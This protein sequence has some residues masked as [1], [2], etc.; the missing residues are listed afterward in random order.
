MAALLKLR[1]IQFRF[2]D[3]LACGFSKSSRNAKIDIYFF[4]GIVAPN[5]APPVSHTHSFCAR[6]TH[7]RR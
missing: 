4:A 7:S 3:F 6:R 5:Y 1:N 2:F